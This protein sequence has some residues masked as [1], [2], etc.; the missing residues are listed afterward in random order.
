MLNHETFAFIGAGTMAEAMI[1]GLLT[2]H[3]VE[4]GLLVASHP[5]EKRRQELEE[6]YGIRTLADNRAAAGGARIVVL[7]VKPQVLPGVLRELQGGIR[8]DALVLSIVAGARLE[9]ITTAL[10]HRAVVR[11]M[12]NTPAQVG[13][14]MTVWCAT[15][16]VTDLQRA[17]TRAILQ[18]LGRE[19][20]VEDEHFLDMATAVSGTGPTYVFLVM[21][22]LIDAAV[23]LGFSRTMARELVL[24]T[25]LGSVIFAEKSGKHMAEL[26]NMVTSP[27]GTSAEAL[28]QLEKG[29]LRTVLSK[30]VW[31]AYQRSI[32]L[33]DLTTKAT[34]AV[35][36]LAF[37]R[38]AP[39]NLGE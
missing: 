29:G 7:S 10:G 26:R 31:A 17:Q 8:H 18:A 13:Q 35:N 28:Y 2:N 14:G 1:N 36:S 4:P 22:A 39:D 33:G 9:V 16:E 11:S 19:I 27:G 21:E 6:H 5:R 24:Q 34:Q 20:Y 37:E 32:A 12:P 15:S 30:G 3:L 25:V 38:R 23:H